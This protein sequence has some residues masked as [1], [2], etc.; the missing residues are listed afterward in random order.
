MKR[1]IVLIFI[2]MLLFC[3]PGCG[4]QASEESVAPTEMN[5][6]TD[7]TETTVS[8][9]LMP[10]EEE[11]EETTIDES[12]I[13]PDAD[14]EE[15][16]ASL[17]D[18]RD[19]TVPFE[20]IDIEGKEVTKTGITQADISTSYLT[21]E[22]LVPDSDYIVKGQV[23][24]V[25][26]SH[27][28]G[29][30]ITFYDVR[31]DEVWADR[32]H[33]GDEMLIPGDTIT[34]YQSG[35]YI[36][37]DVFT[38][39]RSEKLNTS[40]ESVILQTVLGIPL[41]EEG[42]EYVLFLTDAL[43]PAYDGVYMVTGVYQGRY[44]IEGEQV[45]RYNPEMELPYRDDGQTLSQL[46]E[47]VLKVLTGGISIQQPTLEECLE[48][49]LAIIRSLIKAKEKE[50]DTYPE[51]KELIGNWE[52]AISQLSAFIGKVLSRADQIAEQAAERPRVLLLSRMRPEKAYGGDSFA[53]TLI[54]RAGAVNAAENLTSVNG[55]ETAV[56]MEQIA[57]MNPDIIVINSSIYDDNSLTKDDILSSAVLQNVNAVK[58]GSVYEADTTGLWFD[59]GM[60]NDSPN[61]WLGL[62]Y[63]QTLLY[64]EEYTEENF[65]EN[66][67]EYYTI[68]D[69]EFG[70]MAYE[71][72]FGTE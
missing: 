51:Y 59:A 16:A 53:S 64:P 56:T 26:Y 62:A 20:G 36:P 40:S 58:N 37:A 6:G 34:I 9:E 17:R 42:A 57:E 18:P 22:T 24:K 41:P 12:V 49:Y 45:S 1:T 29:N 15:T 47:T 66:F 70:R 60:Q 13:P 54:E 27:A 4:R 39:Y 44:V 48:N 11:P 14:T 43:D 25:T 28:S 23:V 46:K 31:L 3:L 65:R 35:G 30:A 67:Q 2:V 69:P 32:V 8:D 19:R 33:E 63:L 68:L 21:A 38:S 55:E 50:T 72:R 61:G 7:T 5:E 10:F 71:D 52:S